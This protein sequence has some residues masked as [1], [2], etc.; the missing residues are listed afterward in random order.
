MELPTYPV[1]G[2][3]TQLHRGLNI[4]QQFPDVS[5]EL[6]TKNTVI[7]TSLLKNFQ[8]LVISKNIKAEELKQPQRTWPVSR[9]TGRIEF[10]KTFQKFNRGNQ[11]NRY[12]K[13][14]FLILALGILLSLFFGYLK[15]L[16]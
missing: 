12:I 9:N 14:F 15:I 1:N 13:I 10:D 2:K 8:F 16:F 7:K 6:R 4:I 5:A 3:L 11:R